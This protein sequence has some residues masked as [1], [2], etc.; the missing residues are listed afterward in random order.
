L[1][2][3]RIA[4]EIE[5]RDMANRVKTVFSSSELPM[6]V[7][8]DMVFEHLGP[9]NQA[10]I[11]NFMQGSGQSSCASSHVFAMDFK[12]L[13]NSSRDTPP[14]AKL[15]AGAFLAD[16][17]TGF[18]QAYDCSFDGCVETILFVDER[19]RRQ[20]IG[21]SLLKASMEWA[22]QRKGTNLRFVCAKTD[23]PMRHFVQKFGARLDLVL[24]QMIA[25]IPLVPRHQ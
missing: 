25:D 18:V 24:G 13:D 12:S 20:G 4:K 19:W 5:A 6:G 17:L 21:T 7:H 14:L 15:M 11:L 2:K 16:Q 3:Q 1:H 22:S 23:W 8:E 10:A 9:R